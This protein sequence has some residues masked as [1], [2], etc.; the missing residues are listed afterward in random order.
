MLAARSRLSLYPPFWLAGSPLDPWWPTCVSTR[1]RPAFGQQPWPCSL[2]RS[3]RSGGRPGLAECRRL[4]MLKP[5]NSGQML[6]TW[7]GLPSGGPQPLRARSRPGRLFSLR[8][9]E[10]HPGRHCGPWCSRRPRSG[11]RAPRC[12]PAWQL[13][14]SLNRPSTANAGGRRL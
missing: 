12:I 14:S 2:R 10:G 3:H 11:V 9:C 13:H 5:G 7:P 1:T 6:W 8:S 4:F